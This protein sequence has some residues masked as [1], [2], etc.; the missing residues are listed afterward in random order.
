MNYTKMCKNWNKNAQKTVINWSLTTGVNLFI[1]GQAMAC[2]SCFCA[3]S[4]WFQCRI[5]AYCSEF[6]SL[7]ERQREKSTRRNS[8]K[9]ALEKKWRRRA[10]MDYDYLLKLLFS[11]LAI[12]H[13]KKQ[14]F[15]V[16]VRTR[17]WEILF[18][19]C[20]HFTAIPEN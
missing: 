3:S 14:A 19:L 18:N 11:L 17:R 2:N 1:W 4:H 6:F 8:G 15:F 7:R 12:R 10:E 9:L 16:G 13:S 5:L 20:H